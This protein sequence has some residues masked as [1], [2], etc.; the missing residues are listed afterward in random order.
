MSEKKSRLVVILVA[1]LIVMAVV[2]V[3]AFVIKPS[4]NGYVTKLQNQGAI[5][6]INYTLNTILTLLQQNGGVVQ[7]PVPDT[8]Q[9]VTLYASTV[10]PQLCSQLSNIS[11]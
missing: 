6:G 9:T 3:Y 2:L 11:K 7:I 10:I 4:Y 5:Q 8:N 1:V